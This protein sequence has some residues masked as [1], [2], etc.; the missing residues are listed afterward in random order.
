MRCICEER[1]LAEAL[2]DS[3]DAYTAV[4]P[5]PLKT[6]RVVREIIKAVKTEMEWPLVA[7]DESAEANREHRS[8]AVS[9]RWNE[10]MSN[11]GW[12]SAATDSERGVRSSDGGAEW[13]F[14]FLQ[15]L[16]REPRWASPR[17]RYDSRIVCQRGPI[18]A[19]D[20]KGPPALANTRTGIDGSAGDWRL[21]LTVAPEYALRPGMD[22][23]R[24]N[25]AIYEG[26]AF[27]D[28]GDDSLLELVPDICWVGND[29]GLGVIDRLNSDKLLN[30]RLFENPRLT[31]RAEWLDEDIRIYG[32]ILGYFAKSSKLARMW[33]SRPSWNLHTEH[34]RRLAIACSFESDR[35]PSH[36]RTTDPSRGRID[37]TSYWF[38][39][40]TVARH[41]F[42][43]SSEFPSG[44][45]A[46]PEALGPTV[47]ADRFG[48]EGPEF[49]VSWIGNV[50]FLAFWLTFLVVW[51]F[52]AAMKFVLE[53]L[54][55]AAETVGK[56]D[57]MWV[58]TNTDGRSGDW[59]DGCFV[60]VAGLPF[61]APRDMYN[62]LAE[63]DGV[64]VQHWLRTKRVVD[65][66]RSSPSDG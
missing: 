10:R 21:S 49:L 53:R 3:I 9:A 42:L 43:G 32:G 11:E 16:G 27:D 15:R 56:I 28:D 36:D 60:R 1:T 25:Y 37:D 5:Y 2:P 47:P 39:L 22:D 54:G 59:V 64:V 55:G 13:I 33:P 58:A 19:I 8:R 14:E 44:T 51:P 50:L 52:T 41:L 57:S 66:R 6:N 31:I 61:K 24:L 30:R 12:G 18:R 7:A 48:V 46:A 29:M 63:G 4:G 65:V 45:D 38:A 40:D 34:N 20:F 62:R 35:R 23:F 17:V 26:H